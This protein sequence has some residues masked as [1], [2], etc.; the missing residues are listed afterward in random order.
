MKTNYWLLKTEPGDYSWSD[1]KKDGKSVW[2]GV[3][4]PAAQKNIAKMNEDDRVFIYHTGK[5]RAIVGTAAVISSPYPDPSEK[6]GRYKAVDVTPLS[7][8]SPPVTLA[9]IK[10]SG[11]FP[12]WE[13][14]RLPR[15][16]V[17]PVSPVQW[18]QVLQWNHVGSD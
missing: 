11:L 18:N 14:V 6:T 1:L 15:L 7:E 10:S 16:S 8:I 17:V 13:L 2:D 9:Q 12:H 5:E 3:K 4:A